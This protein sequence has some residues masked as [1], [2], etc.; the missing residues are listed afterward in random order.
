MTRLVAVD[1][2]TKNCGVAVYDTRAQQFV[3]GG[4]FPLPGDTHLQVADRVRAFIDTNPGLF[5]DMDELVV[6]AQISQWTPAGG[7]RILPSYGVMV[8]F[9][10]F[11]LGMCTILRPGDVKKWAKIQVKGRM[12]AA[13]RY[14]MNKSRAVE[15]VASLMTADTHRYPPEMVAYWD[16]LSKKDDFADAILL[17]L[18]YLTKRAPSAADR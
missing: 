3:G 10:C 18:Y 5:Q 13:Q 7:P 11:Y 6:E 15:H 9:H 14:A 1:P 8:A 2:G 4:V 17:A 12:T 16:G